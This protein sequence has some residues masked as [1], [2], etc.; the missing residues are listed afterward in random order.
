MSRSAADRLV[1][2][3]SASLT[4]F[5]C[6]V[7]IEARGRPWA[8]VTFTGERHRLAI[9]LSGVDAQAAADALLDGI[10]ERAFELGGHILIDI[11]PVARIAEADA[12][13]VSLEALTIEAD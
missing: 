13:L 8:S 5:A 6:A 7:A 12:I 10:E 1:R 11:A 2:A 4:P 3:L 9:R